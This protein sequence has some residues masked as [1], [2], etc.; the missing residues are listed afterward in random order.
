VSSLLSTHFIAL[1][2]IPWSAT[3]CLLMWCSEMIRWFYANRSSYVTDLSSVQQP[4]PQI[5]IPTL[6]FSSPSRFA[7]VMLNYSDFDPSCNPFPHDT[8]T[9]ARLSNQ[10]NY[11]TTGKTPKSTMYTLPLLGFRGGVFPQPSTTHP[12]PGSRVGANTPG[13]FSTCGSVP[14]TL[15]SW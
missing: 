6:K 8:T 1:A 2:Q 14:R 10:S 7:T 13:P 12:R 3:A 5:P 4:E 9:K 11:H 15:G